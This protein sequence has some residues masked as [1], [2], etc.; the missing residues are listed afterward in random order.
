MQIRVGRDIPGGNALM[1]IECS[2]SLRQVK[3]WMSEMVKQLKLLKLVF[4]MRIVMMGRWESCH[5]V[6][7][8]SLIYYRE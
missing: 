7:V 4:L 3:C 1:L 2:M 6:T 5:V 8:G